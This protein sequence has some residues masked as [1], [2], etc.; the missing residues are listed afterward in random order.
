ML[1]SCADMAHDFGQCLHGQ[2]NKPGVKCHS[3]A[4]LVV[5]GKL[6]LTRMIQCHIAKP[7]IEHYGCIVDLH[8]RAG[9]REEAKK[10]IELMQISP[11]ADIWRSDQLY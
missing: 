5:E 3:Y 2:E 10:V 1:S 9:L 6:M 11:D 4:G 7:K 8:G